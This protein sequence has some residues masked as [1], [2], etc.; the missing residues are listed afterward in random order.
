MKSV[1]NNTYLIRMLKAKNGAILILACIISAILVGCSADGRLADIE[2]ALFSDVS[3]KDVFIPI[4]IE[5]VGLLFYIT[6]LI[7]DFIT[8]IQACMKEHIESNPETNDKTIKSI[9][10]PEKLYQTIW[11]LFGV[12]LLTTLIA[13][14]SIMSGIIGQMWAYN[15][16]TWLHLVILI[17]ACMFE[18]S[19][20]GDNIERTV[21]KK[22]D[23]FG[24][25]DGLFMVFR[26]NVYKKAEN[27]ELLKE[28]T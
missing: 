19:S 23:I 27:I 21:G 13:S 26:K 18:F 2:E 4:T 16:S 7:L 3:L 22:P 8:G 24:F 10:K 15:I 12:A 9:I 6:F 1:L 20:I 11:K 14:L 5:I 25:I 17:A 28:N